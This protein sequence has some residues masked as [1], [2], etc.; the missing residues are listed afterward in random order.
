M[1][2]EIRAF[3]KNLDDKGLSDRPDLTPIK[4]ETAD[5]KAWVAANVAALR[6]LQLEEGRPFPDIILGVDGRTNKV[7]RDTVAELQVG[8]AQYTARDADGEL[9]IDNFTKRRLEDSS[10]V[11]II[12]DVGIE[13]ESAAEL[14]GQVR[15][16]GWDVGRKIEVQALYAVQ[17]LGQ[18]SALEAVYVDYTSLDRLA[19]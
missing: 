4:A 17:H 12:D 5:H 10:S 18:L 19:A 15:A 1:A 6:K 13:G 14:A 16:A 3:V 7:A 9:R 2:G 11:L 8:Y